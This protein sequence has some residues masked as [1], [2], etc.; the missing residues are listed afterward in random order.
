MGKFVGHRHGITYINPKVGRAPLSAVEAHLVGPELMWYNEPG[1]GVIALQGDG[2]YL[3]TNGKDQTIKLWDMRHMARS[4]APELRQSAYDYRF[5]APSIAPERLP[6]L[7][8]DTSL[9]TYRGHR[10]VRTLIR[11]KFSPA[12]STG[13]QYIYSGSAD[14]NIYGIGRVRS[15]A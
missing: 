3:I 9:N 15:E 8:D 14:G 2:R 5:M 1:G 12:M 10:V 4:N 11:A 7:P 6:P 13:Q